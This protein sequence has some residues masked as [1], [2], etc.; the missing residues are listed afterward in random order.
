[1]AKRNCNCNINT[2]INVLLQKCLIETGNVEHCAIFRRKDSKLLAHSP[3]FLISRNEIEYFRDLYNNVLETRS[4]GI[5]FRSEQYI[6]VRAD[7]YSIYSKRNNVEGLIMTRT[8]S[9]IIIATYAKGMYAS[10]CVEAVEKLG[11]Y[12]REKGS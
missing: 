1:M 5:L 10:V 12:F 8:A 3:S 7:K 11:D 4:N 6:T 9:V 2:Q